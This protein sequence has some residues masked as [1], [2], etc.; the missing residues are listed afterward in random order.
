M[1]MGMADIAV[2]LWNEHLQHNPTDPHWIN[3]DF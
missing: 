2:G 3:R 1:P